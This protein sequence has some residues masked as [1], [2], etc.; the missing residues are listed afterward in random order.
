V[1]KIAVAVALM[2]ALTGCNTFKVP[3]LSSSGQCAELS[4][5]ALDQIA[6]EVERA[7]EAGNRQPNIA[8]RGGLVVSSD[9]IQQAIKTRA[10]RAELVDNLLT[11]GHAQ[12]DANG[13]VSIVHSKEYKKATTS[14]QRSRDALLVMNENNDRWAVYEGMIKDSKLP[15]KCLSAIQASFHNARVQV[16]KPGQKYEDPSGATVTK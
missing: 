2:I 14:K 6:A 12:E 10:A 9:I 7:V 15:A 1:K 16:L 11:Q 4:T 5:D 3:F 8:D 13:L